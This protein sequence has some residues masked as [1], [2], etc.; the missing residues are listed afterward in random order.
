MTSNKSSCKSHIDD[1]D[2]KNA[3]KIFEAPEYAFDIFENMKHQEKKFSI[4]SSYMSDIQTEVTPN[5][6]GILIDWMTQVSHF[7]NYII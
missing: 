3:G 5:M 2:A 1:I 6:R 4:N 7:N